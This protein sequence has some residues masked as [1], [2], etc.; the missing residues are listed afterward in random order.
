MGSG[1]ARLHHAAQSRDRVHL[2]ARRL[3]V[4]LVLPA[5]LV[6]LVPFLAAIVLLGLSGA[7]TSQHGSSSSGTFWDV[8]T[9]KFYARKV[10]GFAAD[11]ARWIVSHFATGQLLMLAR[12]FHNMAT[13]T[14]HFSR[15]IAAHTH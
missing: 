15:S 2:R 14:I 9:G 12:Y 10:G 6:G 1:G 13:L 11:F 5:L 4:P 8:I 7:S 3:T